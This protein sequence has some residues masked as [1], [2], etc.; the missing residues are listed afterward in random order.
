MPLLQKRT[1]KKPL[2]KQES[3]TKIQRRINTQ[4][5]KLFQKTEEKGGCFQ[6]ILP[7]QPYLD[8]KPDKDGKKERK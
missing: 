4:I 7:G 8:T 1:T 6:L 2:T 5:L 3:K